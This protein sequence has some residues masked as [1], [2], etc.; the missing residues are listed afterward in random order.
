[1]NDERLNELE[2]RVRALEEQHRQLR[3]EVEALQHPPK[4]LGTRTP[5]KSSN[6]LA[7]RGKKGPLY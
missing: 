5:P 7:K 2:R 1:M 6:E 4:P 3:A